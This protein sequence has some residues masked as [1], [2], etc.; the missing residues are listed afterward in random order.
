[1][2]TKQFSYLYVMNCILTISATAMKM[3]K[4]N[5]T[6]DSLLNVSLVA[7]IDLI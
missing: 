1:M 4:F 6:F 2:S 3:V 5:N 7:A